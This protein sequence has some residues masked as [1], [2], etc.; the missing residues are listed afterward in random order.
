ML[1]ILPARTILTGWVSTDP[2]AVPP[3]VMERAP[4]AGE[5]VGKPRLPTDG[6]RSNRIKQLTLISSIRMLS[7]RSRIDST[8]VRVATTGTNT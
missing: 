7:A 4:A 3:T 1:N 6:E 2:W 8:A 5:M